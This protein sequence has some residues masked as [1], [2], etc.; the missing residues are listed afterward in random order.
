MHNTQ[1]DVVPCDRSAVFNGT[2][3]CNFEL[4]WQVS[5]L[6]MQSAP[7]AQYFCIRAGVNSFVYRNARA[8]VAGDIADA[9]AAGLY[10]VQIDCG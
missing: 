1:T 6:W 7:L 5:E 2:G 4:T 3:N 8:F 9:I 10:A